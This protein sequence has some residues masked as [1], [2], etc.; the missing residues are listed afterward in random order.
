M[1][2]FLSGLRFK[3]HYKPLPPLP[4]KEP[5][6]PVAVPPVFDP[7]ASFNKLQFDQVYLYK[8]ALIMACQ[9]LIELQPDKKF[10][11]VFDWAVNEGGAYILKV[12]DHEI[13]ASIKKELEK[14][15]E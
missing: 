5:E 1:F 8:Y 4:S 2:S 15:G 9:K 13:E 3:S 14:L 11:D 10:Q 6:E 7:P 12:N